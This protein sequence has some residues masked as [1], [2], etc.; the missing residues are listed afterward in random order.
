M[1]APTLGC[2]YCDA[3]NSGDLNEYDAHAAWDRHFNEVHLPERPPGSN[4][5]GST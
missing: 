4:R 1:T 5:P 3:W 2:A